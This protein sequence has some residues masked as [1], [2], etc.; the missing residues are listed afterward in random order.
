MYNMTPLNTE[1]KALVNGV[2]DSLNESCDPPE[3]P[4]AFLFDGHVGTVTTMAHNTPISY[5]NSLGNQVASSAWTG[6]AATLLHGG[7]TCHNHFTLPV[8]ITVTIV[9]RIS[10]TYT[11]LAFL[12]SIK[13]FIIDEASV[14]PVRALQAIYTMLWDITRCDPPLVGKILLLSGD[15][16]KVLVVVSEQLLWET[17]SKDHHCGKNSRSTGWQKWGQE[18]AKINSQDCYFRWEMK[19]VSLF[20]IFVPNSSHSTRLSCKPWHS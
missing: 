1:H 18:V 16:R 6:I 9:C 13:M 3:K 4:W 14:V 8:S 5:F 11:D 12:H 19:F 2:L 7:R 15:F 10:P 20:R 17:V